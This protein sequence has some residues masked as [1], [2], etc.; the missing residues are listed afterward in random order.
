MRVTEI[1]KKQLK[2]CTAEQS[3][4]MIKKMRREYEKLVKVKFEFVDA[5]GG[6][7]DFTDRVFPGEAIKVYH[8]AH[9]EICDL[10]IGL[11]KRLNNTKK[12]IRVPNLGEIRE[13]TR[14]VPLT[15]S[16]ISRINCT[17]ID[18]LVE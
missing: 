7:L 12:K 5:Q 4:E 9:G 18:F 11:V 3:L 14:G 8:I 2:T 17:P 6:W 1:N 13:G 10:P 15:Y 16:T